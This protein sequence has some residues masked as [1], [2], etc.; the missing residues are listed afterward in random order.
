MSSQELSGLL[1]LAG[2]YGPTFFALF[3]LITVLRWSNKA[4]RE[5]RKDP[6]M[7]D[8]GLAA[9]RGMFVTSF[10]AGVALVAI[11][12]G[13]W[14]WDHPKTYT[15]TGTIR[16]LAS[17]E[18]L[19]SDDP[20]YF[21]EEPKERSDDDAVERRNEHFIVVQSYPFKSGQS[22]AI[23]LYKKGKLAPFNCCRTR[24]RTSGGR[25]D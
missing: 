13:W 25:A 24:A 23:E 5:A 22:F 1:E 3:F 7:K 16:N 8:K 4:W 12:V 17:Y 18:K 6:K 9:Y 21:K 15:F 14:F 2:R 20:I 10:V 11:S 19:R